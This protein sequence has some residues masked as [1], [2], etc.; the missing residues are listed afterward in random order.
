MRHQPFYCE[1]N[2][3]WLVQEPALSAGDPHAVFITNAD[4]RCCFFEQRASPPGQPTWWDYHVIA[5]A[6]GDAWDLDSRLETPVPLRA[7]L[8]ATFRLPDP[9]LRFRAVPVAEL[10]STFTTDRSHMR[11]ADGRYLQ[12]PPPWAPPTA[13]GHEMNLSA[14]LDLTGDAPGRVLDQ[15][16]FLDTFSG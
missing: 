10:L 16:G 14:F 3:F 13:A 11:A 7:Y 1:E 4:R 9:R 8:D 12:L 15:A 6:H 5:T 2:V